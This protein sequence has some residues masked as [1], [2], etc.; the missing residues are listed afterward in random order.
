MTALQLGIS[1]HEASTQDIQQKEMSTVAEIF[2]LTQHLT[3][4]GYF[5]S[6]VANGL[7]AKLLFVTIV[8]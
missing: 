3:R 1:N 8:A 4:L 5:C 7:V 2:T 6:K